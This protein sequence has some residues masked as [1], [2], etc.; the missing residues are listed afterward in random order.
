MYNYRQLYTLG[1]LNV[2]T[3]LVCLL[4]IILIGVGC[5]K[6][7]PVKYSGK[8]VL[9]FINAVDGDNPGDFFR[10]NQFRSAFTVSFFD[11][12]TFDDTVFLNK[13]V[14]E[15]IWNQGYRGALV[16][17]LA[18]PAKPFNRKFSIAVEG[19]G[20]KYCVVPPDDSLYLPAGE[21]FIFLDL[22]LLRPPLTDTSSYSVTVKLVDNEYFTP[23]LHTWHACQY[24][25]GNILVEPAKRGWEDDILGKYSREKL[26]AIKDAVNWASPLVKE[27]LRNDYTS[28]IGN[29]SRDKVMFDPFSLKDLYMLFGQMGEEYYTYE[30]YAYSILLAHVTKDYLAYR[31]NG[32]SPVL[33]HDGKEIELP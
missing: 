12:A 22:R 31:K 33:D 15:T 27:Q 4:G 23:T 28:W 21:M 3:V 13:R 30:F 1:M 20:A 32:G 11:I 26:I 24:V 17:R 10:G 6:T 9:Y 29:T 19:S 18:G 8:E 2:R 16:V 5:R 7:E 25:F 14:N